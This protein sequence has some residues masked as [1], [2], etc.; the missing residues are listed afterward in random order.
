MLYTII[1]YLCG[2]ILILYLKCIYIYDVLIM[3]YDVL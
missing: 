1:L 3:I 2:D